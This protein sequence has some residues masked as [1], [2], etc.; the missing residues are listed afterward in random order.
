MTN[1]KTEVFQQNWARICADQQRQDFLDLLY[2]QYGRDKTD[3]PMYSLYTGLYQQWVA[4][5][6][7][8]SS[9]SV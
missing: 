7:S 8:R 6:L 5:G 4:D 3:H 2:V 1:P 9:V